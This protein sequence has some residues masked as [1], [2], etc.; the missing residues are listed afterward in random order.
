MVFPDL[1]S[2]VLL[3]VLAKWYRRDLCEDSEES[4]AYDWQNVLDICCM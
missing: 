2:S 4:L 1:C 3:M